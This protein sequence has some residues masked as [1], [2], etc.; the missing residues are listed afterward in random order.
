MI[1]DALFMLALLVSLPALPILFLLEAAGAG[2]SPPGVGTPAMAAAT[3]IPIAGV[4]YLGLSLL[5]HPL[6][7]IP[8]LVCALGYMAAVSN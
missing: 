6:F 5:V 8:L 1:L 7:T 3:A 4:C 2:R